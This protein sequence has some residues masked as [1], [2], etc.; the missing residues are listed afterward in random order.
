[1]STMDENRIFYRKRLNERKKLLNT[2][3]TMRKLCLYSK[4]SHQKIRWNYGIFPSVKK[5]LKRHFNKVSFTNDKNKKV[6]AR[7][8]VNDIT[9]VIREKVLENKKY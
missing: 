7:L 8:P 3:E 4:F 2:P 9:S 6:T 1:M 5:T